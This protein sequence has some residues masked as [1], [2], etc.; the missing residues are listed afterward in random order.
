[1]NMLKTTQKGFTLLEL[2]I[3][4][5]IIGILASIAVPGYRDYIK[6][7]K[8]VE[9]TSNLAD[10]KIKA[11]QFFQ[12]NRTYV[13]I[14]CAPAEAKNFAYACTASNGTG[15]PDATGFRYTATG[16]AA[17]GMSGF[18]YTINEANAKTSQYDGG[19]S[20]TGCW[21]TTKAGAC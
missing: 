15:T 16:V 8:A 17:Q 14:N 21:V 3:V 7:G 12:D 19:T 1:M 6:K 13:G 11:E 20:A 18:S 4:V 9:A 10:L 2:M 5:A